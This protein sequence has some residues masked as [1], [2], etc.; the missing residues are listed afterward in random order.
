MTVRQLAAVAA[1][2]LL[3]ASCAHLPVPQSAPAHVPAHTPATAPAPAPAPPTSP[4]PPKAAANAPFSLHG[5][6]AFDIGLGV[7]LDSLTLD[8]SGSLPLTWRAPGGDERTERVD[9]AIR[10]RVSGTQAVI[11]P[12][13]RS[14]AVPIAML[15]SRDTLWVGDERAAQGEEAAMQ[16]AGKH[17]RG[18]FKVFFSPRGKLTVATRLPLERYLEGVVPGEIGALK[19]SLL[20]AGRAQAIAARSYSLFY[21]GRRGSEGF[22]LYA[23]VEDQ[24]YLPLE[25][26]RPLA[27]RCVRSTRGQT[28]LSGGAPIRAN[29]CSTCGGISAEAWEAWPTEPR[30]YL[31]AVADRGVGEGDHCALSPQYRWR[32]EWAATDFMGTVLRYAPQQGLSVPSG[33]LG[34][35]T[36]VQVTSRSRSGRVWSLRVLGT[37]GEI[38]IPAYSIRQVL[39]RPGAT[40]AILRSNLFK[41]GVRRDAAGRALAVL[42]SGAGSGHGVGL[43]QTGALAMARG[44]ADAPRILAHYYPS[45]D[46]VRLY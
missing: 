18:R 24:M 30:P 10:I 41:I 43:C 28:E 45:A 31:R 1:A 17:W 40:S 38:T 21:K 7:D 22:D 11:E 35:L 44:G 12:L 29:Y 46:L 33:G 36:D 2:A 32:E 27:T 14:R 9:G 15:S 34:E 37:R 19:D 6:P 13:A 8:V 26:E 5:E 23:T 4:E 39:R 3:A 16:W 20:E 25:S 42:V